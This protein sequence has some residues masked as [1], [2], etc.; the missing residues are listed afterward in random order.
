MIQGAHGAGAGNANR[1]LGARLAAGVAGMVFL[2]L[3][4]ASSPPPAASPPVA[5][6]ASAKPAPAPSADDE[7]SV[8]ARYLEGCLRGARPGETGAVAGAEPSEDDQKRAEE[9]F[10]NGLMH[11]KRSDRHHDRIRELEDKQQSQPLTATE[12]SELSQEREKF[13][14]ELREAD[15]EYTKAWAIMKTYVHAA[16]LGR[17]EF[18]RSNH[19]WATEHLC[20]ALRHWSASDEYVLSEGKAVILEDRVDFEISKQAVQNHFLASRRKVGALT[21]QVSEP[22]ARV[23]VNRNPIGDS[24]L[25]YD[26]YV[27]PKTV[28]VRAERSGYISDKVFVNVLQ[29]RSHHVTVTLKQTSDNMWPVQLGLTLGGATL[30]VA[31]LMTVL[32]CVESDAGDTKLQAIEAQG[33][34][35]PG[36]P[37]TPL[38]DECAH[39]K[40]TLKEHDTYLTVAAAMYTF[41]ALFAG[42][43]GSFYL[44]SRPDS[45]SNTAVRAL[46]VITPSNLG[47]TVTGSF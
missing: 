14:Q 37:G 15:R 2:S 32:T 18:I 39:L 35:C 45:R 33:R 43:A 28:S 38:A 29:G 40:D 21:I 47:L 41:T 42:A 44:V 12:L 27:E 6:T 26:V 16:Y 23:F 5:S 3:G 13:S 34:R 8:N 24:P 10:Q 19:L 31:I 46:P 4:C 25:K 1:G 17:I 30:S 36:T 7:E 20:F 11:E 9:F 22:G